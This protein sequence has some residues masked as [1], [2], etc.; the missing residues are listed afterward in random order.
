M[1]PNPNPDLRPNSKLRPNPNPDPHPHPNPGGG[2]LATLSEAVGSSSLAPPR[3]ALPPALLEEVGE[4]DEEGE[5]DSEVVG[6][7]ATTGAVAVG[8]GASLSS[9][10][11]RPVSCEM[12]SQLQA[13]ERRVL[14]VR[15]PSPN[16]ALT[17]TL[18]LTLNLTLTRTGAVR[19]VRFSRV[20][21]ACGELVHAQGAQ[22][23]V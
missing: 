1:C 23:A 8:Q 17:L 5:Q 12:R 6:E 7:V 16:P 14:Q 9:S 13:M 18:T 15:D 21:R 19:F 11:D 20:W 3:A 2:P 10:E 4:G 22:T